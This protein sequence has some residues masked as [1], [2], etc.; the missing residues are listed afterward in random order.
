MGIF[1]VWA[2]ETLDHF[3]VSYLILLTL[4]AYRQVPESNV[5]W[6]KRAQFLGE[7]KAKQATRQIVPVWQGVGKYLGVSSSYHLR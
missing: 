6:C 1:D 5:F 2:P 4:S 3:Q 7:R